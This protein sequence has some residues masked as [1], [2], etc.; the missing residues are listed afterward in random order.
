VTTHFDRGYN[1][2]YSPGWLSTPSA[3]HRD[4]RFMDAN[5]IL[6]RDLQPE[7]IEQASSESCPLCGGATV[8]LRGMQ[9]CLRCSFVICDACEGCWP[10]DE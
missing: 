6:I 7:P 3:D 9:R 4:Q 10:A 8:Q 5:D 2:G 1:A